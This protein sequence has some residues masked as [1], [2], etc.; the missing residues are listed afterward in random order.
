MLV[1]K[2]I[3]GG[4]WCFW[5]SISITKAKFEVKPHFSLSD[6]LSENAV[7][8]TFLLPKSAADSG[9]CWQY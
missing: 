8:A 6:V 7:S 1:F 3:D 5:H 4:K 2:T 9:R